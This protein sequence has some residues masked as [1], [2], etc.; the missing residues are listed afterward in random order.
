MRILLSLYLLLVFSSLAEAKVKLN[1]YTAIDN[2]GF[3]R[4]FVEPPPL[5]LP[6]L[7]GKK[8]SL[9]D[10]QGKWML[11][12]FWATWC[13]P[14]RME[15]PEL[16]SLYKHFR[17]HNLVILGIST[18]QD[19]TSAIR[20]FVEELKL[21]FPI[22]HDESGQVA[23]DYQSTALPSLYLISPQGKLVGVV[24]GAKSWSDEETYKQFENLLKIKKV[25]E[26]DFKSDVDASGQSGG[27]LPEKLIPPILEVTNL[28]EIT[29]G[30]AAILE[31]KIHWK[32]D[33]NKYRVKVPKI[34]FPEN[35]V[36]NDNISSGSHADEKEAVLFYSYPLHFQK[37][38]IFHLGPIIMSFQSAYGGSE[39]LTRHPGIDVEVKRR[40]K[41]FLYLALAIFLVMIIFLLVYFVLKK[42]QMKN[43]LPEKHEKDVQDWQNALQ[44][45]RRLRLE[46]RKK[47]YSL[48][49]LKLNMEIL[50]EKDG[51]FRKIVELIEQVRFAGLELSEAELDYYEKEIGQKI[52]RRDSI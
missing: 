33:P 34:T 49:L 48:E 39:Q 38:G 30:N 15:L 42:K 10:Y 27:P 17:Q 18:D 23:A 13:G 14:C 44:G 22:L 45:I 24:R 20:K 4:T 52:E 12:G 8:H 28:A 25:S 11:L 36:L 6:D 51:N 21:S 1:P 35:V 16:E 31:V 41:G 43:Q 5:V 2:L 26:N 9:Q 19:D 46:G 37:E 40:P 50:A 29:E 32:G 3:T 47:E 7:Q